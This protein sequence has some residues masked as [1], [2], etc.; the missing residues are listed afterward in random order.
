MAYTFDGANKLIILTA[1]TTMS[2]RD[3]YSRWADWVAANM[4]WLPA[5]TTIGGDDIDVGAGTY[6][7]VYAYLTNGWR[8]RPEESDHT[9]A[10]TDGVLLVDG[11]GD[12][13]VDTL[14]AFTV[15]VN[16]QQPV[17]AIGVSASP[18]ATDIATMVAGILIE[19]AETLVDT[20]RLTRSAVLGAASPD[21]PATAFKSADGS[22][23]R[24]RSEPV[25]DS[26]GNVIGRL[27][28]DV[29]PT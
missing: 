14:G 1:Q 9:L 13:F 24:F 25:Y 28:T 26:G 18:T 11:G 20:M 16:Y 22:T 10:V 4:Q 12:P 17:Q 8:V 27:V 21:G 15:R 2:V 29:D 19:G 6:I 5:F 3:V 23:T 7:P